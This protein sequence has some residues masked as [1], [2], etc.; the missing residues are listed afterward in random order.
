MKRRKFISIN[1]AL[2]PGLFFYRNLEALD[3]RLTVVDW[4]SLFQNEKDHPPYTL[5]QWMNGCVTKEGITYDLEA[6][7]K[8]GINDV[9]QFLVGGS[10]A[11][12]TDPE[13]TVLGDKWMELMS[14][15]LDE[16]ERL[17]MTF[18]T[19]N[20]PGW[21]ASGRQ[22]YCLRIPCKNWFGQK[23][24]CVAKT[25]LRDLFYHLSRCDI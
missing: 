23:L 21:S 7:K 20:C 14:F 24:L 16:C 5:W 8:A 17:G 11:D 6:F 2:A 1:A 13:V 25:V 22:E 3:Y 19:H 18:G 4:Q 9:Q 10:E 15:A 12:I